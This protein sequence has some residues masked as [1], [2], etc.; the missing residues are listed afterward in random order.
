MGS[1]TRIESTH[2]STQEPEALQEK[3]VKSSDIVI[4][5]EKLDQYRSALV[6]FR[7]LTSNMWGKENN[8]LTRSVLIL[9]DIMNIVSTII[10]KNNELLENLQLL[11][12]QKSAVER[13]KKGEQ[14]T[15]DINILIAAVERINNEV[16]DE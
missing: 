2:Y 1:T 4:E 8:K 10:N 16:T 7:N 9:D 11:E 6:E 15:D 14:T 3:F 12:R 13:A 5:I